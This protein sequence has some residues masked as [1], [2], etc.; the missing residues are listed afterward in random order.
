MK[1]NIGIVM[2]I[3]LLLI[4]GACS[5][6]TMETT[7]GT[8]SDS[9]PEPVSTDFPKSPITVLVP[10]SPGSLNDTSARILAQQAEKHLPNEQPIKIEN[11]E[12][13]GGI[14]AF[15]KLMNA[16]PDGYTIAY[17]TSSHVSVLPH[18]GQAPFTHDSFQPIMKDAASIPLLM[19]PTDAP[20]DNFDEWVEYVKENPGMFSYATTGPGSISNLSM[21]SL[22]NKLNLDVKNVVYEGGTQG[23]TALLGGNIDGAISMPISANEHIEAG[24]LKP[25]FEFAETSKYEDVKVLSDVNLEEDDIV[26]AFS[27]LFAPKGIQKAELDILHEAFS[28]AQLSDEYKEHIKNM[29]ARLL[30]LNPEESQ[31]NVTVTYNLVGDLLKELGIID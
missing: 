3:L 8:E 14:I 12:G 28:K 24:T 31:E 10:F 11:V 18:L 26:Q 17:G 23:I 9:N 16:E 1:K 2:V 20:Y 27:M 13:G 4:I 19:V 15:T 29:E 7:K 22:A 25:I 30:H 5:D 21:M 6:S